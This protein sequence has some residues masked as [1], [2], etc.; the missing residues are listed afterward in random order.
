MRELRIVKALEAVEREKRLD[1]LVEKVAGVVDAV[2]Q[3]R[4]L[5]DL[6]HGVPAGHPLHPVMV[7][8]PTGAWISAALLDLMPGQERP[9][10]TLVGAGVLAVA[11]SA[12]AGFADWSATHEQQKRTGLVH[13]AANLAGTALY[14][15]SYLQRLRGKQTS[16]KVLSFAGL[17][18]V[19][20][21]GFIGGHLAYR[22]AVGANHAEDV[23]HL[24]SPGWHEVTRLD[25]LP[26]GELTGLD[27]DGQ[28]LVA[29][30]RGDEVEVLSSVCSHLSGPLSE[31]ELVTDAG[32]PGEA[33]VSCPWHDSV[34]SMRT[35]EVVHGPATSPQPRFDTRVVD[36]TV[37]VR[38]PD[39]G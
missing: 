13:S 5:R 17:G 24:V 36:G 16:A 22:Q 14:G 25:A 33:C 2:L 7:L 37:E 11:P 1:P 21:G 8:V 4:A 38:L 30:R 34:F 27:L 3:P 32:K 26:E 29:L 23:P 28:P 18:A 10:R 39:A 9:A 35:G 12:L 6:L 31:G 15:A 19:G 20:L